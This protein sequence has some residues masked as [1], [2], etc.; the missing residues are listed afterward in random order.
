MPSRKFN[1]LN[2]LPIL[3]VCSVKSEIVMEQWPNISFNIELQILTDNDFQNNLIIGRDFLISEK[4]TVIYKPS[5]DNLF[6]EAQ[7]LLQFDICE[8]RNGSVKL[9][10]ELKIDNCQID[11]DDST[12]NRLKQ[13]ILE[14][15]NS[16]VPIKEDNH[17]I[18]VNL[19]DTSTY[20]YAPASFCIFEKK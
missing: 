1:A 18:K 10:F 11:F 2:N 9:E 13:L 3:T 12:K 15:A 20:A 8:I 4:L 16:R 19:R 6:E 7:L 5:E 17:F 14:V